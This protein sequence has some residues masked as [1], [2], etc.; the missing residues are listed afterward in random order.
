MSNRKFKLPAQSVLSGATLALVLS[1]GAQPALADSSAHVDT[2]MPTPSPV[3]SASAQINHEEGKAIVGVLVSDTGKPLKIRLE[4]STGFDDL[5]NAAIQAVANWRYVPAIKNGDATT[6]W[7]HVMV[8]FK[9]PA[10]VQNPPPADPA[11]H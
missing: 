7:A 9:M 1:L 2:S 6:D 11:A 4:S 3:Y 5:D 8:E 10:V